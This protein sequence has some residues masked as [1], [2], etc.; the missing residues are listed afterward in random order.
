LVK[1][2]IF[3][4][5]MPIL[6]CWALWARE[7]V[8]WNIVLATQLQRIALPLI[9][10]V[11]E[12][13]YRTFQPTVLI[14]DALRKIQGNLRLTERMSSMICRFYVYCTVL[15]IWFIGGQSLLAQTLIS[16]YEF[17][18]NLTNSSTFVDS[19]DVPAPD[20]TFR[21]GHFSDNAIEGVPT[22]GP[23]VDTTANGAILLDGFDDWI[24]VTTVGLPGQPV[25][26]SFSSGPGLITGTVMAW[27]KIDNPIFNSRWLMGSTNTT[28]FQSFHIGWDG[29]KLKATVA[30][31]DTPASQFTVEDG[32]HNRVWA[33]GLWHHI[34]I[35]WDGQFDAGKVYID[36]LPMDMPIT[37]GSSLSGANTQTPWE[38][39]MAIG[40]RN[41]GGSLE[42]FWDGALDDLRVYAEALSDSQI[43]TIFEETPHAVLPDFDEDDDVDGADFLIWQ[44]GVDNGTTLAEGDANGNE[45]VDGID[46]MIWQ[47]AFGSVGDA[48]APQT[49]AVP[50]PATALLLLTGVLAG[51]AGT[52]RPSIREG[53]NKQYA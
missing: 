38:L 8:N 44:R 43:S 33:D 19:N 49:A 48:S 1:S 46:L 31:A 28:D 20:G 16:Q 23:G 15:S 27:I 10:A 6:K 3:T 51:L 45:Q 47:S 35:N 7:A 13:R 5:I 2:K 18:G 29:A 17:N 40:A 36:G 24:D 32:T 25:P 52:C 39:P 22:F 53:G 37:S 30:A 21:E 42:G 50:E 11:P 4:R 41:N 14:P 9:H 26:A 34:A 12:Q